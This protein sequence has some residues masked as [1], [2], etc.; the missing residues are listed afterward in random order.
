MC[1]FYYVCIDVLL[2]GSNVQYRAATT[3][4]RVRG[5]L[6]IRLYVDAARTLPKGRAWTIRK[7]SAQPARPSNGQGRTGDQYQVHSAAST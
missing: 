3:N 7:E 1:T 4:H 5:D 6:A 2:R